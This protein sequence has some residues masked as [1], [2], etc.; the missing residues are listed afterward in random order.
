[1]IPNDPSKA[2]IAALEAAP[3]GPPMS[4]PWWCP[5]C[6]K[7]R[8]YGT[9]CEGCAPVVRRQSRAEGLVP[10]LATVPGMFRDARFDVVSQRAAAPGI[11]RAR[12]AVADLGT[13]PRVIFEGPPGCGKTTLA[14]C[15][16]HAVIDRALDPDADIEH[17]RRATSAMYVRAYSLA[18]ANVEAPLGASVELVE[19]CRA[20]SVLV[21]DELG[22]EPRGLLRNPIPDVLDERHGEPGRWTIVTTGLD[23]E[24]LE[25]LYGGG[26]ARRLYEY[27]QVIEPGKLL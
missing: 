3:S 8:P 5:G 6:K 20:A 19:R 2:I 9:T 17:W 12:A 27:A 7:P 26:I 16:L 25:N 4:R 13:H 15:M 18:K 14:V 22:G 1:M 11:A 24:K 23:Q 21:I 10:A